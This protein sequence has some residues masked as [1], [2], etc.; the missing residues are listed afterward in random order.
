M[1]YNSAFLYIEFPLIKD[2][3]TILDIYINIFILHHCDNKIYFVYASVV[4]I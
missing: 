3:N 1:K 2:L 4:F